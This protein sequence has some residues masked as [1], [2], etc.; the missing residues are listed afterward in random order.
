M[1]IDQQSGQ[2]RGPSGASGEGRGSE[3][4]SELGF[5]K[6]S[7]GSKGQWI[8]ERPELFSNNFL[9]SFANF[10]FLGILTQRLDGEFDLVYDDDDCVLWE[11]G[12]SI[13]VVCRKSAWANWELVWERGKL[14]RAVLDSRNYRIDL[15]M[16]DRKLVVSQK[17]HASDFPKCRFCGCAWFGICGCLS[18]YNV[19]LCYF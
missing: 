4:A 6:S 17:F 12:V 14:E 7:I 11:R 15:I 18:M 1:R 9:L 13:V 3:W 10:I 16:S 5:W 2:L 19:H 8:R